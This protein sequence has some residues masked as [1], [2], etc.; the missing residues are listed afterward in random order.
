MPWNVFQVR[1]TKI[2]A[3]IW[4]VRLELF[5]EKGNCCA[6][7]RWRI[8][9]WARWA[10]D[11]LAVTGRALL[12]LASADRI[13][14]PHSKAPV[15]TGNSWKWEKSNFQSLLHLQVQLWAALLITWE[16]LL[17]EILLTLS[18]V[19]W[20]SSLFIVFLEGKEKAQIILITA[21]RHKK[22]RPT[23]LHS[24]FTQNCSRRQIHPRTTLGV[25]V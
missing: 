18:F 19:W 21:H 14:R 2:R 4:A 9:T 20:A 22:W 25:Y 24:A 3:G 17:R 11:S 10:P 13:L 23:A 16:S 15:K 6:R 1:V 5:A 12:G 7:N 8:T